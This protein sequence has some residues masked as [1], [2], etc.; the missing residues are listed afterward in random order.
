MNMTR[1]RALEIERLVIYANLRMFP[2]KMK[3]ER[4]FD[5]GR[6][7]GMMHERLIREL[8]KEIDPEE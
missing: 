2:E 5:V 1:D 7:V 4:A 6:M 8:E 3:A